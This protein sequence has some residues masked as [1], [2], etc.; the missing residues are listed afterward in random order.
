MIPKKRKKNRNKIMKGTTPQTK[1]ARERSLWWLGFI[2]IPLA[3]GCFALLPKAPAASPKTDAPTSFSNTAYGDHALEHNNGFFDSA[4]GA[5]ALEFNTNGNYNTGTGAFALRSN[6]TGIYNTATGF[7]ALYANTEGNNNTAT[8]IGALQQNNASNNT[9]DGYQ[10]LGSN[11]TGI[12]NT[13]TGFLALFTNRFGTDNT[14]TG[15]KALYGN[16]FG[17][18]N[19]ADGYGALYTNFIGDFNT[20]LGFKALLN[21]SSA[22]NDTGVGSRALFN[23][24]GGNDNTALGSD[25]LFF[26]TTGFSNT[27]L[28]AGAGINITTA[29]HVICVGSP[30]ANVS[31]GCFIGN[32]R[33]V[34]TALED[35]I[36]VYI[37]SAGQLGTMISSVRFKRE[38]KPMDKASESILA[39]KPVTFRYKSDKT[40][41]PQFGLIAEEVAEV[42]PGLVVH[43]ANGKPYTVRYD[44]VNAMLL[45][46]FLKE[47]K[48]V[49][50]HSATIAELKSIAAEQR[51]AF[52]ATATQQEKQIQAL[53]ASLE[54]Q[55]VQI[56]KVSAQLEMNTTANK[57]VLNS[58]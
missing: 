6:T 43:D 40:N 2:V 16:T 55:A 19:T 33:G 48:K 10:A 17:S 11:T 38:I 1:S 25:A 41:R 54:E 39:L 22:A 44:Q 26:N 53:T 5:S 27:A 46:E 52:E 31:N 30:G 35:A 12:N 29:D 3:L 18:H 42:N 34:T 51:K 8:G 15:G 23:N 37:D 56:Q 32:I 21:S 14:A 13:A 4:F 47:H 45:N 20:A 36:P 9:A 57:V 28:G 49:Q 50:D 58:P 7:A 24:T